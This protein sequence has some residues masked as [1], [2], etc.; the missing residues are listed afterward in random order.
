[1]LT[2]SLSWRLF[3]SL[4]HEMKVQTEMHRVVQHIYRGKE[5]V[6]AEALLHCKVAAISGFFCGFHALLWMVCSI[7]GK[8]RAMLSEPGYMNNSHIRHGCLVGGCA[9]SCSGLNPVLLLETNFDHA[10]VVLFGR[11]RCV[12]LPRIWPGGLVAGRDLRV[13]RN[14]QFGAALF[15]VHAG[16]GQ[17]VYD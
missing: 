5:G 8:I 2:S 1:M 11:W 10:V 15:H 12:Y 4:R 9:W 7:G 14:L 6:N 17:N 3:T 16:R 13:S